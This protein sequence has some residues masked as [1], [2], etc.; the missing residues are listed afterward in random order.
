MCRNET[1]KP[2]WIKFG[3]VVDIP[4]I[5]TYTNFGVH[6]LRVFFGWWGVKFL[7]FPYTFITYT[8]IIALTILSHTRASVRTTV[9]V[10]DDFATFDM[11]PFILLHFLCT[12]F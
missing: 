6:R 8:F 1:P 3:T 9:R 7:P 10:S 11:L 4:D 5:V 2:I 12:N